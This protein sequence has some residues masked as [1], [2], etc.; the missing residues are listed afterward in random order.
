MLRAGR[1]RPQEG[2]VSSFRGSEVPTHPAT[3]VV[4]AASMWDNSRMNDGYTK[5]AFDV[6]RSTDLIF[7]AK[8]GDG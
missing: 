2:T 3:I 5:E 6:S 7:V 4:R 8:R 1:F